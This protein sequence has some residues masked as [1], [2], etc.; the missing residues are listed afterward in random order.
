MAMRWYLGDRRTCLRYRIKGE[1][2]ASVEMSVD[3]VVHNVCP[4]GALIEANLG[5]GFQSVRAA[6]I[7]LVGQDAPVLVQVRHL[8]PLHHSPGEDRV[9]CGVEFVNVTNAD[10]AAIDAF[11]RTCTARQSP[12]A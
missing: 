5:P 1:L 7:C 12:S 3:V 2:W 9:L 8:T 11:V 6:E 10:R 4:G